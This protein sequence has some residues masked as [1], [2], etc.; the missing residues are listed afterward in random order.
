MQTEKIN[1][2]AKW[3]SSLFFVTLLLWN[4]FQGEYRNRSYIVLS[5][6]GKYKAQILVTPGLRSVLCCESNFIHLW[7]VLPTSKTCC[8]SRYSVKAFYIGLFSK[9][10]VKENLNLH[11][12]IED[13]VAVPYSGNNFMIRKH[14]GQSKRNEPLGT[15][16]FDFL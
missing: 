8:W 6:T 3:F 16:L 10:V 14:F 13:S 7:L 5:E 11:I 9:K 15:P 2:Y 4:H 1:S 12:S